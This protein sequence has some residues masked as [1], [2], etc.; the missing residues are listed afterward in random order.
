MN[1]AWFEGYRAG[2]MTGFGAGFGGFFA[3]WLL[4]QMRPSDAK[5]FDLVILAVVL[6]ACQ[7]I[8]WGATGWAR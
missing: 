5:R 1:E 6:V 2:V 7:V 8:A 3:V 4:V